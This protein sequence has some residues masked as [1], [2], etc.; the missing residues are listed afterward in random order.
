MSAA[1]LEL[2]ERDF[3][4]E[5]RA[6]IDA[7]TAGG[8]YVSAQVAEHIVAKLRATDPGLLD[9]WLHAQAVNFLRHAINLRDCSTRSHARAVS[10]RR[11]FGEAA[12]AHGAGDTTALSGWL[13]VVHVVEDGT[14]KRL[15][16][17][18]AADLEHVASDY[19]SRAAENAMHATFLR[20]LRKK[21]GRKAVGDVFSEDRLAEMWRSLS[22]SH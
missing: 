9:G 5:M 20:A 21:V 11:A 8:P 16:E 22:G 12:A 10:G 17:M 13:G 7:E 6:V 2:V 19:D 1:K 4:A 18:T 3:A 15:S 14:R